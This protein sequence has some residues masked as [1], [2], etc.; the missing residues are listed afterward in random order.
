M[1]ARRKERSF[2]HLVGGCAGMLGY[3]VY[4]VQTR[5]RL[6][7]NAFYTDFCSPIKHQVVKTTSRHIMWSLRG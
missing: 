4:I 7:V 5:I 6:Y 3:P 2:C 1:T